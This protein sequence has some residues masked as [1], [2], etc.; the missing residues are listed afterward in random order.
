MLIKIDG[1][2]TNVGKPTMLSH[3]DRGVYTFGTKNNT[4]VTIDLDSRHCAALL[5]MVGHDVELDI[6]EKID[7]ESVMALIESTHKI[8]M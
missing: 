1:Q 7:E 5:G 2:S 3:D 4:S 8:S 6:Q